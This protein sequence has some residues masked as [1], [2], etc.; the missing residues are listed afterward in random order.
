MHLG[1]DTQ[2]SE[3]PV[4][5]DMSQKAPK[6]Y[7]VPPLAEMK[8]QAKDHHY[9]F[10]LRGLSSDLKMNERTKHEN[11]LK[12]LLKTRG[13]FLMY[14]ANIKNTVRNSNFQLAHYDH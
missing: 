6:H 3:L 4:S 9:K 7:H 10:G 13:E 5:T 1:N 11:D 12:D 8:Q 2:F 14:A